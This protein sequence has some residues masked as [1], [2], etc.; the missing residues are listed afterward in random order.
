M[1]SIHYLIFLISCLSLS[2]QE[3]VYNL[4]LY[5]SARSELYLF[6][7]NVL[8]VSNPLITNIRRGE[9]KLY[10]QI[11]QP[12]VFKIDPI[13]L[14]SEIERRDIQITEWNPKI[15]I[16]IKGVFYLEKDSFDLDFC[17]GDKVVFRKKY[18][19]HL[20]KYSKTCL[21]ITCDTFV[22]R[23]QLHGQID[24]IKSRNKSNN[25]KEKEDYTVLNF[26]CYL[27]SSGEEVYKEFVKGYRA[28]PK[29]R[30]KILTLKSGDHLLFKSIIVGISNSPITRLEPDYKVY[31]K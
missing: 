22:N 26:E 15:A 2:S 19:L 23:D 13:N 8:Y 18:L 7:E 31:I 1:K 30:D 11:T 24:L 25:Y 29:L 21:N 14:F 27:Y 17:S 20:Y 12:N 16:N 6:K 3:I 9:K 28:P 5:D 4:S 10:S